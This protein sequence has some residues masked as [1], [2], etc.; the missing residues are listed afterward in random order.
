[1]VDH[2][3]RA[4]GGI[5]AGGAA[6]AAAAGA[7]SVPDSGAVTS[8]STLCP[9]CGTENR[10]GLAFCRNCGQRLLAAGVATTVERPSTAEGTMACPRCGTHNRAGVAFCQNCG[11]NLRAVEA[12]YVPPAVAPA[13]T[14][15]A[16]AEARGGAVLGP[17]VLIIG[18]IG[19]VT[20]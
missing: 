20:A 8:E 2:P 5:L 13:G 15:A 10:A 19:I 4:R 1:M 11:A 16:A 18:L 7:H 17:V 9:R 3:A 6:R 14:T 12:G